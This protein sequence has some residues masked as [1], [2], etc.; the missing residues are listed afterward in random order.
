MRQ[1]GATAALAAVLVLTGCTADTAASPPPASSPGSATSATPSPSGE[2]NCTSVVVAAGDIVNDVEVADATGQL[3][4][5][6]DPDHVLVLGDNQYPEGSLTDYRNQYDRISWGRLKPITKP[7]PGNHEYKTEDAEGYYTYFDEPEPYYAYDAGCGWRGY[8][9]N[10]EIELGPQVKWLRDDLAAH[11]DVPIVA[12]WH[13][14]RWSS[15][16]EHGNSDDVQPL[17]DGLAGRE[18]VIL[19]GHDHGY[20]RFAPDDGFREFVVGTGGTSTYG[21][22]T[23]VKGSEKRVAR[24]PG[25][26]RLDL[27]PEGAYRWSFLDTDGDARDEGTSP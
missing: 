23:P 8:A 26:L 6:Q 1:A 21:F 16:A 10:S 3:A 12:S 27:G 18:G 20:E 22:D 7:V 15:G 2:A 4:E 5:D 25:V 13:E 17:V 14:P 19:N 24:T 11:P 9:L